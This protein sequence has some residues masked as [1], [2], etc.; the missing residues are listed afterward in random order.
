MCLWGENMGPSWNLPA[1]FDW[2]IIGCTILLLALINLKRNREDPSSDAV[3]VPCEHLC[4]N[5]AGNTTQCWASRENSL[6]H[7]KVIFSL[8]IPKWLTGS[9]LLSSRN[10]L[11]A[12]LLKKAQA[13]KNVFPEKASINSQLCFC[14]LNES[15]SG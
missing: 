13:G 3:S 5:T 15:E 1:R 6:F 8:P 14:F 4:G 7:S 9:S 2:S 12:D 11:E 10:Q